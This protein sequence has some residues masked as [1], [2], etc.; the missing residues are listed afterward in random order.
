[1]SPAGAP[2]RLLDPATLA[3]LGRLRL[4]L[5]RRVDGRFTGSHA[6]R[7]HGQS[8]DFADYREY[9]PGDDPRLLDPHAYARL[10]RRLVKLFAAEDTAAVRVVLDSSASMATTWRS[11]QRAAAVVVALAAIGGDR[12]RL[13]VAGET[14]DA[15]PWF[16][17]P[18]ALP[19]AERRL[20]DVEPVGRADLEG[21]LRRAASEG[22]RGP[23]VLVSDMLD[24]SWATAVRLLGVGRGDALLVHTLAREELEPTV[25]GDARLVDVET[26]GEVEVA[27]TDARLTE[28][29]ARRDAW[30]LDVE[31]S[32]RRRGVAYHRAVDD[33]PLSRLAGAAL[34]RLGLARR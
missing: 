17:G 19:A 21:A 30:L 33:D 26:G 15:G 5:R 28:H 9:L 25:R 24:E 4:A 34:L 1:M 20:A 31:R 22:P 16:A 11:A 18:A 2:T 8:L 7:G 3:E 10:G 6:A 32:C 23:V 13:L 12:A 14:T 29:A 27:V